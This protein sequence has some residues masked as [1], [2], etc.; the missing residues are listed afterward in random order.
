MS[1]LVGAP[2]DA[3]PEILSTGG[4]DV[5]TIY[6]SLT[7]R[8]PEGDDAA[9][10]AWHSLDHR[11]EQHRL[12]TLR[13]S[14]RLV[15]TP[16]C[17]AARAASDPRYDAADHLMT[18]LFTDVD[19]LPAFNE[20]NIAM[21]EAG[22]TPYLL[23]LV[24]RA[25]YRLD[26]TAAAAR[27]KVGADVLPWWPAT[28][29][30]LL[31]E[32]GERPAHDLVDVDGVGGAWWG[33]ALPKEPPYTTQDNRGLQISYLF[34]DDDPPVVGERL[35]PVL[36]QRWSDSGVTPLLAAPFHS[37]VSHDWGRYVP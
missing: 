11:P 8:H 17:R 9:Y 7:A 3:V 21:A 5:T 30:Y 26:G 35:R 27:V 10:L 32:H 16:Q 13:A 34:L 19:G 31:I 14:F 2:S 33:G 6:M 22:R 23:P 18:Y 20:L 12:P 1:G 36:A 25:V 37:L 15:S 28:G 24:E 29:V 4:T